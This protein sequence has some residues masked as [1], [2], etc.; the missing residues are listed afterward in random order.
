MKTRI[1]ILSA[2]AAMALFAHEGHGG[3]AVTITAT[4]VDTGCYMSHDAIGEK[5]VDCATA[6]AKAGV[7][8]ALVDASGKLYMPIAMNH[9]NPNVQLMPFIEKKVKVTGVAMEKGGLNGIAIKTIEAV[10]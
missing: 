8:L 5:H 2:I 10:P 4:V 7:P 6:C 3:K 1:T 9:K